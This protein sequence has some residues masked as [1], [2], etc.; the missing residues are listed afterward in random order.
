MFANFGGPLAKA[1]VVE[2]GAGRTTRITA[3]R[4]RVGDCWRWRWRSGAREVLLR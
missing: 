2:C 1:S 3:C 4:C